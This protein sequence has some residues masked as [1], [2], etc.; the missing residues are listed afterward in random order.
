SQGAGRDDDCLRHLCC[1]PDDHPDPG[2]D[3]G[4]AGT[5]TWLI[6]NRAAL[7]PDPDPQ[8]RVSA[9]YEAVFPRDKRLAFAR[10]SCPNKKQKVYCFLNLVSVLVPPVSVTE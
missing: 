9:K 8:G 3:H 10:R 1:D 4:V 6:G 7:R 2:P 5:A